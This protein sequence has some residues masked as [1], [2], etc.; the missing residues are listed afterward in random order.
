MSSWKLLA[1]Q[2]LTCCRW[3]PLQFSPTSAS[4]IE[5]SHHRGQQSQTSHPTSEYCQRPEGQSWGQFGPPSLVW[6]HQWS[7]SCWPTVKRSFS[8]GLRVNR[9]LYL[10]CGASYWGLGKINYRRHSR[11]NNSCSDTV[12][13]CIP[14][15]GCTYGSY[16]V[17]THVPRTQFTTVRQ[18][19]YL[20]CCSRSMLES[21]R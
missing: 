11:G 18:S 2:A 7:L 21:L 13:R 10:F 15:L 1:H 3:S 4:F 5:E 20:D 8:V 17:T 16:R 14:F 12:T 19:W 6:S 9:T